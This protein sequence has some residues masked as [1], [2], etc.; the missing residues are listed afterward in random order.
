MLDPQPPKAEVRELKRI[1]GWDL[2]VWE[3]NRL[4]NQPHSP[5][6]RE[7]EKETPSAK[8]RLGMKRAMFLGSSEA[9][10]AKIKARAAI[11]YPSIE[12]HT[13]SPPYKPEFS[14]EDNAA[15]VA[16]INAVNPNVLLW[17]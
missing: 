6:K 14:D 5:L 2:F 8:G 7:Q 17:E 13:Y 9:V 4:N 1:A 15:M 10:L 11:E 3:M 16:A 12:V